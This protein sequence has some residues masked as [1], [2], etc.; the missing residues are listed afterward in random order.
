[1]IFLTCFIDKKRL[2][3]DNERRPD[4]NDLVS[5]P[6]VVL[7][8][9]SNRYI[10]TDVPVSESKVPLPAVALHSSRLNFAE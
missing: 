4:D 6:H 1:M 10:R 7:H 3:R 8:G 5:K 9:R 2:R